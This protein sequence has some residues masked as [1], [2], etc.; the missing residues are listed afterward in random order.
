MSFFMVIEAQEQEMYKIVI[1]VALAA[2]AV[3]TVGLK[4]QS[5]KEPANYRVKIYDA[6][7]DQIREVSRLKRTDGEWKSLLT[8]EQYSI[9]RQKG[10]EQAFTGVCKLP[11]KNETGIYKCVD[12]GTDLFKVGS[13]FESGTGWP[14][15][16]APV[17][18][19]N[20]IEQQDNSLG[21]QRTEILCARCGAHL[22]HVFEDGPPPTGKR[23]CVNS[24]ALLLVP[25]SGQHKSQ[26]AAFAAG[27]FWGVESAFR[28][29]IGRGVIDT[30]VGYTGGHTKNPT[31]E[32]VCTHTTGHAETVEVEYDPA[33]ISYND[34]LK[35][36]WQMHDPTLPN[37][38][39][40]Q[41]RSAI[42]YYTP[43]QQ[44]LALESAKAKAASLGAN[45]KVNTEITAATT[46]YPAEDYHQQFFEKQGQAPTCEA[47]L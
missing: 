40:G 7:S 14:S 46:F 17:S 37:E 15:F 9:T 21:M 20:V 34:L 6:F 26:K 12:C 43:E 5:P 27:C 38:P 23:Y 25:L 28:Q 30:R 13:K 18:D 8:P 19:L 2:A 44:K 36:F 33:L 32:Q 35:A 22:G 4:V 31:Y 41:Y 29:L 16:W 42:F 1:L 3:L 10:T 45:A 11:P 47:H 39:G 24:A